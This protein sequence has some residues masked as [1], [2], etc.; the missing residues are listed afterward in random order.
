MNRYSYK[1]RSLA[2]LLGLAL[3]TGTVQAQA[4]INVQPGFGTLN[5]ALA[6]ASANATLVLQRGGLYILDG[7]F[8]NSIPITLMASAGGTQ[9][10]PLIIMGVASGGVTPEQVFRPRANLTIR[11][12][13]IHGE[14]ELSGLILRIIRISN[15]NVRVIVE[16][17]ELN[18]ASQAAFRFDGANAKVYVRNSIISNI[19][20]PSSIDNGRAFDDRG[21]DVDTILSNNNTYYNITSRVLR[22]G[23]GNLNYGEFNHDT[24]FNIGLH[25]VSF[26]SV[27][28][29]RTAIFKNNLVI[30]TGAFGKNIPAADNEL[31]ELGTATMTT[32]QATHVE[33]RNNAFYMDPALTAV[34]GTPVPIFDARAQAAA[35]ANSNVVLTSPVPF[36]KVPAPPV[37]VAQAYRQQ[38]GSNCVGNCG[39]MDVSGE[40]YNF[41]YSSSSSVYTA[42]Q[43]GTQLGSRAWFGIFTTGVDRND[44]TGAMA[45]TVAPNPFGTAATVRYRMA[46]A[47]AVRLEVFDVLGRHVQERDFGVLAAGDHSLPLDGTGLG[48][49]V[50]VVR[51][52]A[53]DA[54]GTFRVSR[55]D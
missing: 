9:A 8:E 55:T 30:N 44:V 42:G 49:G 19:G 15:N 21:V 50:Y 26:G 5:A 1:R 41:G 45:L 37:Q 2:L 51:V 48:A 28:A 23:G 46:E 47:G 12:L 39:T 18:N 24:F 10:L 53:G 3:A 25:A 27:G 20:R 35:D 14:D 17:S 29:V 13:R 6:S 33:I 32:P 22:D 16:N 54:V 31:I 38:G 11:N 36:F 34:Q 4:T 43:G 52:T 7:T 40:P